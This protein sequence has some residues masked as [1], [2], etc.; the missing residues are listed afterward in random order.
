MPFY[1]CGGGSKKGTELTAQ[2]KAVF[3][4]SS[5][6]SDT[7]TI[8]NLKTGE[9]TTALS[10]TAR[11]TPV[12]VGNMSI[13]YDTSFWGWVFTDVNGLY[14]AY[15]TSSS[16]QITYTTKQKIDRTSTLTTYWCDSIPFTMTI[17]S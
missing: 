1:R 10:S 5:S 13:A 2:Y 11:Y 6:S 4:A 8:T 3:S 14:L 15:S 9:T 16:T 17:P 12:I 7:C